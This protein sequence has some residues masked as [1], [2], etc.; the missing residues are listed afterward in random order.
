MLRIP[1]VSFLMCWQRRWSPHLAISKSS[2]RSM[3]GNSLL[4]V[5]FTLINSI[6]WD[7]IITV[8]VLITCSMLVKS[9]CRCWRKSKK[10]TRITCSKSKLFTSAF[11][12]ET[13]STSS[14]SFSSTP[15]SAC[16][17][18]SNPRTLSMKKRSNFSKR[19]K[20]KLR[21]SQPRLSKWSKE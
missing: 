1:R 16:K 19:S 20:T 13:I 17:T 5:E 7:V 4:G 6:V 2:V 21:M 10:N 3:E 8:Q 14:S 15:S 11:S 18:S 9:S 12:V